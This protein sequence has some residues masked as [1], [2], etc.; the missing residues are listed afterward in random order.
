M[1]LEPGDRG[2]GRGAVAT[3]PRCSASSWPARDVVPVPCDD[4]GLDPDALAALVAPRTGRGCSTRCRRSTTRP[5]ARC[6][7]SA[8]E[9]LATVAERAGLWI[10]EDDPYGELRYRGEPVPALAS[11][12]GAEARMLALSTLSKVAAPGP[13]DRLGARARGAARPLIVAK[14]AADLH[15]STVDQAAAARWLAARRPRRRTSARLRAAYGARRDALLDG[16]AAALPPG[17][18]HNRPDGGMFV[19]ARLPDG[20][21]AERLL[22]ARAR[23]RRRLRAGRAVL[24]RAAGPARCGSRSP[25]TRRRRSPRACGACAPPGRNEAAGLRPA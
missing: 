23:A 2:A 22:R 19:W 18:V 3:W 17:S 7:S 1:L 25:R 6:R 10:V 21:D 12:P 11:L 5:G 9:A 20:W 4:D 15:S 8:R 24:R 16:L 13:A 14:Q